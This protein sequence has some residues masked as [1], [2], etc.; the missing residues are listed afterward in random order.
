M[1]SDINLLFAHALQ[2]RL[3]ETERTELNQRLADNPALREKYQRLLDSRD[4][5][6]AYAVWQIG[7][8][9]V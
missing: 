7:R 1:H 8:A 9:H 5:T 4:L 6:D 2:G 3:T